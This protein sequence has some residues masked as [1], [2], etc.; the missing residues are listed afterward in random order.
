VIPDLRL[1]LR[2]LLRARGFSAAVVLTLTLAI[3]LATALFAVVNAYLV[4][5]LPYPA[6]E[7]L[8][9]VAYARPGLPNPR[10]LAELPWASLADIVEHPIA[11]DLDMFYLVRGEYPESAPGAWVTPGF[12]A[13]LGIRPAL[14]RGFAA[15]E[16]VPGGPQVALISHALWR[17]RFGGDSAVLGRSFEAYVSDRPDDPELFTIVGVLPERFWHLNPYTEVLTPLRAASYPYLVRLQP[18]VAPGT[19]ARRFTELVRAGGAAASPEV[20]LRALQ[21]GYTRTLRPVLAAVGGALGL[22]LLIALANV[23][24]LAV[25]RG[26]R[27]SKEL[28]VRLALGAGR[29]RVARLLV[30]EALVLTTAAGAAGLGLAALLMRVVGPVLH[31]QLGRPVPGGADAISLDLRVGMAVGGLLAL[32]ALV[33]TLAPL[34]ATARRPLYSMLRRGRGS[35]ADGSG[36][37]RIRGALVAVELAGSL[38]LLSACGHTVLTLLRLLRADSG[39]EPAG[40]VMTTLGLRERSYPDAASRGRFFA[41]LEMSLARLPGVGAAGLSSPSPFFEYQ[42]VPL[43]AARAQAP[44]GVASVRAVSPGYFA[45]LRLPLRRGRL[46]TVQDR[47]E[48]DPV[49]LLSE[50]AAQRLWPGQPALGRQVL[51]AA[52]QGRDTTALAR[53]VV[54]IVKDTRHSPADTE[55]AEIYLPLYQVPERFT[56]P[57]LR[58]TGTPRPWPE[59][60][61]GAIRPLNP[62]IPVGPVRE[63][64]EIAAEQLARPRFLTGLFIGFGGFATLLALLGVYGVTAYAVKQREHEVAVRLAIGAG[65]AAIRRLFLREGAVVLLLGLAAGIPAAL[66]IG[67]LLQSQLSGAA[68]VNWPTL[69]A[70]AA[71]LGVAALLAAWLPSRAAA[72]TEP[73]RALN[74]EL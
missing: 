2:S 21:E 31:L 70:A 6:A 62:D 42:P 58:A 48:T 56:A 10:G 72:E 66:G 13:G 23:A 47:P 61:R 46:F 45:T 39:I 20:E 50:S 18:G 37:R 49:V 26:L 24:F 54:G 17:R 27:R 65:P 32:A 73:M 22:V 11:W 15:E 63:L 68:A 7:R 40:V 57:I 44:A 28:A 71:A 43:R 14:G 74:S 12:M 30:G 69:L 34:L 64:S 4:R 60:I 29:G 51:V 53:T 33:L 55:L 67:R 38:A 19:A 52:P 16:Y 1:A 59:A 41:Q 36:A 5:P 25:I 8:F 9:S 3:A 35:G